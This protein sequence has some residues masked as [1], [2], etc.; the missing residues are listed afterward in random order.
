MSEALQ[1]AAKRAAEMR[2]AG[3]MEILNPLQKSAK[4]PDSRALALKAK[5]FE[6]VG[7]T[8]ESS[9]ENWRN[10][11]RNCTSRICPLLNLRPYK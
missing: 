1:K 10:E 8:L 4:N 6:C 11:I 5:C 3:E 2:E 9:P 7:G